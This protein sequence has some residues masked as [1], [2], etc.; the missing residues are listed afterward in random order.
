M[1]L[2]TRSLSTRNNLRRRL[3]MMTLSTV[4]S[5]AAANR[6]VHGCGDG[7]WSWAGAA[8]GYWWCDVRAHVGGWDDRG[9]QPG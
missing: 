8:R 5:L 1:S 3:G 4:A 2:H 7:R 9:S 6:N